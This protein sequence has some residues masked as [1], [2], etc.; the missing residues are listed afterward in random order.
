MGEIASLGLLSFEEVMFVFLICW[1]LLCRI[2]NL[3]EKVV[4]V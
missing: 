2:T 3:V 4:C 1:L